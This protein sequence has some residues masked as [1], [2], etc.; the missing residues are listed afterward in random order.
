M[1]VTFN[2]C[3]ASTIY[4]KFLVLGNLAGYMSFK[5]YFRSS[6]L[7]LIKSVAQEFRQYIIYQPIK[8]SRNLSIRFPFL[9]Y[10]HDQSTASHH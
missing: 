3:N 2:F 7:P 1:N 8:I 9:T 6:N 5:K 10:L 4:K